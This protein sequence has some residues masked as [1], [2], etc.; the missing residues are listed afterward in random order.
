MEWLEIKENL[1]KIADISVLAYN[2][3]RDNEALFD[4]IDALPVDAKNEL[5]NRYINSNG[6]VLGIRKQIAEEILTGN[7]DRQYIINQ[8]ETGKRTNPKRFTQ[9][10]NL[11]SVLYPFFNFPTNELVYSTLESLANKLKS[12]LQLSDKAE[13]KVVGFDGGRNTGSEH[14]WFAI[15]NNSYQNQQNA[16][17]LFFS[18]HNG[19]ISYALYDRS[20][21]IFTDRQTMNSS[22]LDYGELLNYFE[23]YKGVI[24]L[25]NFR[26]NILSKYPLGE[27]IGKLK[28]G[29]IKS[30]LIKPGEKGSMWKKALKEENIRIGW[31]LVIE[32]IYKEDNFSDSFILDKLN[33]HYKSES[34]KQTNNKLTIKSFLQE[35]NTSDVVFAVSGTAD[36]IGVGIVTSEIELDEEDEDYT[37]YHKIDWL[38]DLSK[39]PFKPTYSLPIKTV[40]SIDSIYSIPIIC[41]IFNYTLPKNTETMILPYINTILYGPPGTGKTFQLNKY[42]NELFTDTGITKTPEEVLKEKISIYP[43]WKVLGAVLGSSNIPLT[44]REII[45]NPIVKAKINPTNKT[46]PNNLAW[47]D[48]QSYAD[49]D[50][51]QLV[52]KY[53]RSIM[54]FHKGEESKWSIAEDKKEELADIIDQELLDIAANPILQPVQSTS[55]KIRYNFITF[56]Q[57]YSYEDFIE[58]IKPLLKE[59][60]V[61]VEESA[62][63]LQFELKKGIFYNSCLEAL[64]LVGYESFEEC[65][66]DTVENRIAKF[67]AAKNI[68]TKQFALFIDEINRAN[69][70]AV[71]GE[72]ITLLEDDKRIGAYNEMWVELPYSNEK[73]CVPSNLYVIGTMNTADRSIA[74]LDIALRRRFEFKSLYPLYME[75]VWWSSLLE[76]IN[77]AIY[78]WRKNPDFFIGHA[79]FINKPET[80]KTK[81]LNTK[82]IPLLYEYCQNNAD[83]VKKILSDAG[84]QIKQTGI[85]ENFQIIAE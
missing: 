63:E 19:T 23:K 6:P 40:T 84:V 49:D 44:V 27:L 58:G 85:K 3:N 28:N 22:Q 74:L 9:Y 16:K 18:V 66:M 35:V 78:T 43:F 62:G 53:R 60:A 46:K 73:F 64:R 29:L 21:D 12:D 42:M 76:S 77:L 38:I 10:K 39:S 75:G 32:D 69:I 80:D 48:L 71:F 55:Y 17:Q 72:L 7:I 30:W 56:H 24:L 20:K 15:Y 54:L 37:A 47:A 2:V 51:T 11:F 67:E 8:F 45:E 26:A 59:E 50:S 33:E 81:I 82:I 25:D 31:G 61:D 41:S 36:I 13:V 34:L 14:V 70:S 5:H 57:K 68:Q 4:F 52:G 83:T 79:F 65:Y 1:S